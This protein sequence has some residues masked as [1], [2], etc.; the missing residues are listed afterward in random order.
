L[1]QRTTPRPRPRARSVADPPLFAL[2]AA[3]GNDQ[4][5]VLTALS[6]LYATATEYDVEACCDY[7]TIGTTRYRGSDHAPFNVYL[8]AG[9]TVLWTSDYSVVSGGFTLCAS[10]TGMPKPPPTAPPSPPPP[11][12]PMDIGSM[13]TQVRTAT[14]AATATTTEMLAG[15]STRR[16]T[17]ATSHGHA[18]YHDDG[19]VRAAVP[20]LVGVSMG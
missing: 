13:W 9:S 15:G 3:D 11:F 20:T 5:C 12:P 10:A 8:A 14:A 4:H 2:T 19:R 6:N 7:L 18:A 16:V 1:H 17:D